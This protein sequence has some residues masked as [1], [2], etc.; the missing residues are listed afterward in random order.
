MSSFNELGLST[1]MLD[2]VASLGYQEPT[3]VQKQAIPAI[4]AGKDV[5]AGA[6]T[7]T[8]KTAAFSLPCMDLFAPGGKGCAP[9]MLVVTP[10]RELAQQI[11]EVCTSVSKFT[12]HRILSV[13]GGVSQNPQVKKLKSGVDVLIA[14]PGRL[15][16]LHNQ[17][18]VNLNNVGLFVLDEAD[19]MLDMGFSPDIHRIAGFLPSQH[20]TMLFSATIDEAVERSIGKLLSNPMRVEVARRGEVADTVKQSM[21]RIP[22]ALKQAMLIAL[23][24]EKGASRVIVFARTRGRA[25]SCA[26]RLNKAG[27]RAAAIH[28]DRSQAKRQKALADFESGKIDVIVGTDV[29]ARGIDVDDVSYVVNFDLPDQSEDY[30]HRIGRTGRAGKGGEAISFV[31]PENKKMLKEILRLTKQKDI[32][33]IDANSFDLEEAK[34]QAAEAADPEIA[35]AKKEV[36]ARKKRKEN[37][38]ARKAEEKETAHQKKKKKDKSA[39]NLYLE[40]I[41]K[42]TE[43]IAA[44]ARRD[45]IANGA[46]EREKTLTGKKSE[47]KK[48]PSRDQQVTEK[49]KLFAKKLTNQLDGKFTDDED[50]SFPRR[51]KKNKGPQKKSKDHRAHD[52]ASNGRRAKDR[53]DGKDVGRAEY[54]RASS[55]RSGNGFRS[56]DDGESREKKQSFKKRSEN[57]GRDYRPERTFGD[58][59]A[60]K[61]KRSRASMDGRS[62]RPARAGKPG[63]GGAGKPGY[64]GSSRSGYGSADRSGRYSEAGRPARTSRPGYGNADRPTRTSRPGYG[65]N[66]SARA[67]KPGYGGK[68]KYGSAGRSGYGASA[69]PASH[70]PRTSFSNTSK[71]AGRKQRTR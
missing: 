58:R 61:G 17:R 54:L 30:I 3:D 71:P 29:L 63:Y 28:S 25:D 40:G 55:V 5:V 43:I 19:R 15:I 56:A 11:A 48:K 69:R 46:D 20:Q 57:A 37:A 13:V 47:K 21:I 31:T 44:E 12:K 38:K 22:Q 62:G 35:A 45:E 9:Y 70:R 27:F 23:L 52:H 65:G 67:G 8:G 64:G 39:V 53:R 24:N 10:T 49:S 51:K 14:T 59:G 16:D 66:K 1:T 33:E 2:A 4:L 26:K 42:A 32:P 18:F 36:K 50:D 7:G 68:P 41:E 60:A 34:E 6:K